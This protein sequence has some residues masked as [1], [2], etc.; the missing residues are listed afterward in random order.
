[1]SNPGRQS[2]MIP[3]AATPRA[4]MSLSPDPPDLRKNE[5]SVKLIFRPL[6]TAK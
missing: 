5:L 6:F 1:M 2:L 3:N 4:S